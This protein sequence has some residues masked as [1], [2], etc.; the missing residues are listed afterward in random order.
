MAEL[1]SR[2]ELK[3]LILKRARFLAL[4]GS[5]IG[6]PSFSTNSWLSTLKIKPEFICGY[7]A[8]GP[9]TGSP[10]DAFVL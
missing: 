10:A 2:R 9:S 6:K 7:A 5:E 8:G 1:H 4:S 3:S